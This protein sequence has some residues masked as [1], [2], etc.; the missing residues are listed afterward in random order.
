MASRHRQ[1]CINQL[2]NSKMKSS[3]ALEVISFLKCLGC[4]IVCLAIFPGCSM[5]GNFSKSAENT[6][7]KSGLSSLP[8]PPDAMHLNIVFVDRPVDDPLMKTELWTN[9]DQIATIDS[10]ERAKLNDLGI[11]VGVSGSI[12]PRPLQRILGLKT[13]ITDH[14]DSSREKLLAGR[15][16]VRRSG[17][18]TEIQSSSVLPIIRYQPEGSVKEKVYKNARCLFRMRIERLQDGWAKLDFTPE[19]HYG[20]HELRPVAREQGWDYQYSQQVESLKDQAF[21]LNLNVGEMIV[22]G[23]NHLDDKNLGDFFFQSLNGSDDV[24][25]QRLVVVRLA[26]MKKLDPIFS[27]QTISRK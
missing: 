21:S 11:R 24:D 4:V 9:L 13:E 27:N 6:A 17:G 15:S 7:K 26:D 8:L 10:M 2:C 14:A 1:S 23:R 5:L 19:I 25:K 22:L 3:K 16:L 12:P 20:N 18:E